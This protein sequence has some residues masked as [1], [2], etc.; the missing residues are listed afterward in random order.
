M[1]GSRCQGCWDGCTMCTYSMLVHMAV[2]GEERS[3][4]IAHIG[5][6]AKSNQ[7]AARITEPARPIPTIW[8]LGIGVRDRLTSLPEGCRSVT[9][10]CEAFG[11]S[12]QISA[13]V[14]NFSHSSTR[15]EEPCLGWGKAMKV[16]AIRR[17][18]QK[19]GV[20]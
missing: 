1:D 4:K 6:F 5:P 7:L 17:L 12:H 18:Q 13:L 8:I 19:D 15:L 10:W 3:K 11:A 9:T 16:V 14:C 20:T 2:P